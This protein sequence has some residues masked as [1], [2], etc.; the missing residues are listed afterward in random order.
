MG[1]NET[2]TLKGHV[3]QKNILIPGV[4]D[5]RTKNWI[6][7][8]TNSSKKL[9]E[10]EQQ[11][12]DKLKNLCDENGKYTSASPEAI[13]ELAQLACNVL[14]VAKTN[15]E[16]IKWSAE[17]YQDLQRSRTFRIAMKIRNRF[18]K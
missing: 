11:L 16:A 4:L 5:I 1:Y 13:S 10:L 8:H 2:P 17:D 12:R 6:E 3:M 18:K 14:F 7:W 15:L 9:S